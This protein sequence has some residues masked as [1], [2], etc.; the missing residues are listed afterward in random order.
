[1]FPGFRQSHSPLQPTLIDDTL[2][3]GESVSPNSPRMRPMQHRCSP[4]P[5]PP[6]MVATRAPGPGF[7]SG[8]VAS[9]R[10]VQDPD[11]TPRSGDTILVS[12]MDDGRHP[13][14]I[15]EA[16][17]RGLPPIDFSGDGNHRGDRQLTPDYSRR[18][19]FNDRGYGD[20]VGDENTVKEQSS[21]AEIGK[22]SLQHLAAGALEAVQVAVDNPLDKPESA[23]AADISA[24]TR[25]LSLHDG[26]YSPES[27]RAEETSRHKNRHPFGAEP[28]GSMQCPP[29][30]GLPPIVSPGSEINGRSLPSIRST[31]AD[32]KLSPPDHD[33]TARHGQIPSYGSP[34][35]GPRQ[36]PPLSGGHGSPPISPP[37]S[38]PRSLPSPRSLP[39]SSPYNPYA[40]SL[41]HRPSVDYSSGT[42]GD[43]SGTEQSVPAPSASTSTV[44]QMSIDEITNQGVYVCH[45]TGCKAP[46]FQTQY[47]LNSHANVHSSARP[48]YCPV[49]GCSRSEGGKGFKRKNEMIRHGL[50]H[51]S[52]GY[53]CPFCPERDH[54]YPRPDNLQRLAKLSPSC[55]VHG[56][57]IST[58]LSCTW[59]SKIDVPKLTNMLGMFVSTMLTK[60]RMIRY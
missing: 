55:F 10:H 24:S 58:K 3:S 43:T 56:M 11:D 29:R 14:I 2:G 8:Y 48:H 35:A 46:A 16:G 19:R 9:F 60:V 49:L 47:L 7:P 26:P 13:D 18:P 36:L 57:P 22:G 27:G 53:V 15:Q 40:N 21:G 23:A 54:K 39:A 20:S 28:R 17:I 59:C 5:S 1:M 50:V 38:Y 4:T 37:D 44:D 33:L 52:P 51:D 6:V 25:E 30:A 31:L 41:P 42:G 12:L 32:F 34:P 45:V